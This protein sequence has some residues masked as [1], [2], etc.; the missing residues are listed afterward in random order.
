M[1]AQ[2]NE[3]RGVKNGLMQRTVAYLVTV[4]FIFNGIPVPTSF[5]AH[6]YLTGRDHIR[7]RTLAEANSKTV[8]DTK[9]VPSG[10][11][12]QSVSPLSA[13]SDT[14]NFTTAAYD[15]SRITVLPDR[16]VIGSGVG[17]GETVVSGTLQVHQTSSRNIQMQYS[18]LDSDDFAFVY[19]SGSAPMNL[20]ASGLTV[21]A[22]G[23]PD[24]TLK[25]EI[26]D[27]SNH[28]A[29]V[30]L[31]LTSDFKNYVISSTTLQTLSPQLDATRI[32]E[33]VFVADKAN[34][35]SSGTVE[36]ETAGL[37]Y[38]P[39][40]VSNPALTPADVSTFSG[41]HHLIDVAGP[42]GAFGEVSQQSSSL[43]T[44]SYA[45]P[46][47][48]GWAAGVTSFDDYR[49]PAVESRDLTGM[50]N[51]V[52]GLRLSSGSGRI[53]VEFEDAARN[54]GVVHLADVGTSEQFYAIP[55]S[56]LLA[57]NPGLDL[58]RITN[59]NVVVESH[60]VSQPTGELQVRLGEHP[61]KP[62]ILPDTFLTSENLTPLPGNP[63]I[64]V[65]YG[66]DANAAATAHGRG[67]SFTYNTGIFGWA[68]GGLTF[69]HY[70]TP[71]IETNDLSGFSEFVFG[72]KGTA[73]TIKLEFVDAN[74]QKAFVH[75]TGIESGEE[76]IYRIP[77]TL[78][79]Q[80]DLS[81]VRTIYVIIEG[82]GLQGT[83]DL[84][85]VPA[86]PQGWTRAASNANYAFAT[87][88][89]INPDNRNNYTRLKIQDLGTGE[90]REL[91]S[92]QS[93]PNSY[94]SMDISPSGELVYFGVR[95]DYATPATGWLRVQQVGDA[96]KHADITG[97][98][99]SVGFLS[100]GN[101][102]VVMATAYRNG[103]RIG[104]VYVVDQT[105]LASTLSHHT[106]LEQADAVL[107]EG[108]LIVPTKITYSNT[109]EVFVYDAS[110]GTE[111]LVL[112]PVKIFY[113]ASQAA[114]GSSGSGSYRTIDVYRTPSGK[115]VLTVGV[116]ATGNGDA[117][118]SKTF[119]INL[120]TAAQ[121]TLSGAVTAVEY[122]GSV[123]VCT[124]THSG[125]AVET[126][127]VDLDTLQLMDP[128]L[129]AGWTRA[130]SNVNYAFKI[131]T[132]NRY[133]KLILL[134]L[135]TGES[136]VL[137]K[138]YKGGR[139]STVPV[140]S[141]YDV[142][143]DGATV[144]Y[145][146]APR[147]IYVQKIADATQKLRV[148]GAAKSVVFEGMNAVIT[149]T[150][151]SQ[152]WVDMNTLKIVPRPIP[153]GWTAVPSLA[154]LAYQTISGNKVRV[155]NLTTG[156]V[157]EKPSSQ[158]RRGYRSGLYYVMTATGLKEIYTVKSGRRSVLKSYD[159]VTRK[160]A[161][162]KQ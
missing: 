154:T 66:G 108:Y 17:S 149:K 55:M 22:K 75:L 88:D 19:L 77:A 129:P 29:T 162:F 68:G 37:A 41:I 15:P 99:Q 49:T 70:G 73:G 35:G 2:K 9:A 136:K 48:A 158:D 93:P 64:T 69:D 115:T 84:Y 116:S 47:S 76:N 157:S 112:T 148:S 161:S 117:D 145:G 155:M 103:T 146:I 87:E 40:V 132:V 126:K 36:I 100:D 31:T 16:P 82:I 21:A 133:S 110:A 97:I 159:P 62:K 56:E 140:S 135:K 30:P 81:K 34:A 125:G 94:T 38:T 152:T 144:V 1:D 134:D 96:T 85:H 92:L 12:T 104:D 10:S 111:H 33:I 90:I 124:V 122:R 83:M 89:W 153:A 23:T 18:N 44:L 14:Q 156:A 151:G 143:P 5:A 72:L 11:V 80:V 101:V 86:I 61:Y 71:E 120:G 43:Y 51:L 57:N 26:K 78:F 3:I 102:S 114:G 141:V 4:L 123:A 20:S 160:W 6:G 91:Y 98:P 60:G 45:L 130:A 13:A 25:L 137:F 131:E 139:Y 142:S 59:I 52:L 58:H 127:Y 128:P 28:V 107:D 109:Y 7:T 150:N 79:Q 39:V 119:I 106:L 118:Y 42:E 65:I 54:K 32:R 105:T 113:P 95:N 53:K 46:P 24:A 27:V 74:D 8:S 121:M 50:A 67:G 63:V 147:S 138:V